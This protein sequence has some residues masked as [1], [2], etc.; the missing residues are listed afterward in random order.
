MTTSTRTRNRA[1]QE[2]TLI[3][4]RALK[5]RVTVLEKQVKYLHT[6]KQRMDNIE[7][8]LYD[9]RQRKAKR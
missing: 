7:S 4:L 3:N 1:A 5:A 8:S 2:A 6:V 9:L